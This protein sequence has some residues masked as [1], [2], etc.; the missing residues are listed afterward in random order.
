MPV[1]SKLP[2]VNIFPARMLEVTLML[3]P[4]IVLPIKLV[5]P[6]APNT[7]YSSLKLSFI[8]INACLTVSPVCVSGPSPK[9]MS[10]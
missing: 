10:C 7:W 4:I 9:S 8:F 5:S 1:V 6:F 3:L 2:Y